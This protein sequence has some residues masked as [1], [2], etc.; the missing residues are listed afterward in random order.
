MRGKA[1][2]RVRTIDNLARTSMSGGVS[3]TPSGVRVKRQSAFALRS[4]RSRTWSG[5]GFDRLFELFLRGDLLRAESHP[6]RSSH[7]GRV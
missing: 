7:W 1:W 5:A 4:G 3:A 2:G 6:F